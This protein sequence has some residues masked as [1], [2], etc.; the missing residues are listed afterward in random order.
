MKRAPDERFSPAPD[1]HASAGPPVSVKVIEPSHGW[2]WA[3]LAAVWAYRDLAA[4]LVLRDIKVRYKQTV[5]GS[6]WVLLRPLGT[7]LVYTLVFGMM[8]RIPSGGHPY[9][10]FVFSA[11]LPW[12]FFS[13]VVL[14]AGNCLLASA[15]LISKVY[16][17]RIILP[18]AIAIGGLVDLLVSLAFL[19]VAMP[20]FGAGWTT[21]LFWLP[22]LILGVSLTSLG[23]G[24]LFSALTVSH[25]DFGNLVGYLVQIGLYATPVIYP[26]A[27][28]PDRWRFLLTINPLAAQVEGFRAAILGTPI[29]VRAL[30]ISFVVS[31]AILVFGV[32]WFG[33]V[34]RRFADIL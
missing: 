6:A 13:G 31:I 2:R 9:A 25:R 26:S 18:L 3:D 16:F 32:A 33:R 22:L 30:S 29:D 20:F 1:P 15:P 24:T 8:V 5:L 28:V 4:V 14:T 23:I 10:I 11:L 19:L 21:N 17:P 34:E 27:L 7:M 12:G